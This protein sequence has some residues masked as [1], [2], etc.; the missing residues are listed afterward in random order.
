MKS[1]NSSVIFTALLLLS[2]CGKNL[3]LQVDT[4]KLSGQ[5]STTTTSDQTIDATRV[6]N[7]NSNQDSD[8]ELPQDQ[9]SK[10]QNTKTDVQADVPPVSDPS[11]NNPAQDDPAQNVSVDP[12][13]SEVDPSM[14]QVGVLQPFSVADVKR[15]TQDL[16]IQL[17]KENRDQQK[18][19][20]A[21]ALFKIRPYESLKSKKRRG[22]WVV[23]QLKMVL[24]I[25]KTDNNIDFNNLEV[26]LFKDL[27]NDV[28]RNDQ[29][30]LAAKAYI[31]N[32]MEGS[33]IKIDLMKAFGAK[34]SSRFVEL[35][36][37]ASQP[38]SLHHRKI[39][40][41]IEGVKKVF[42]SKLQVESKDRK[43]ATS[44]PAD[45][46]EVNECNVDG[47]EVIPSSVR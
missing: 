40:F 5:N 9:N 18:R 13:V 25:D 2:A 41:S 31:G 10:D 22:R 7:Q 4:S 6:T 47:E 15:L 17:T 8:Q 3:S 35:V 21:R 12:K 14:N 27:E 32:P 46:D 28:C 1:Y 44:T 42:G 39:L 26:C 11:Q 45:F 33:E 29:Q 38:Y 36:Y 19:K 24:V 16:Q 20:L 37:R 23:G 30:I 43:G 34:T